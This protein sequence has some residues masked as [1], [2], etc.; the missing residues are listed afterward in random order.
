MQVILRNLFKA[1]EVIV[2][3]LMIVVLL[4]PMG[5]RLGDIVARTIVVMPASSRPPGIA[6]P[7]GHDEPKRRF[8][9]DESR[10]DR[11]DDSS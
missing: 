5:Q 7:M 2:W 3:P 1:V 9:D 10:D 6:N 4:S 11:K 8:D